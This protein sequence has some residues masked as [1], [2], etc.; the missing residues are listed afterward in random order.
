MSRVSAETFCEAFFL[1]TGHDFMQ[2][3]GKE[4]AEEPVEQ[5]G[6]NDILPLDSPQ[7]GGPGQQE[8]EQ[9]LDKDKG[10]EIGGHV[11]RFPAG[12][13]EKGKG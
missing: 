6:F 5:G 11:H 10:G 7:K 13:G 4:A 8:E 3:T 12:I 2:E 1:D 9:G